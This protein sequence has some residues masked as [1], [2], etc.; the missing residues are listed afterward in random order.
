[1]AHPE[2]TS[3]PSEQNIS[4]S[5]RRSVLTELIPLAVI[6]AFV[7]I[8]MWPF[9]F[10]GM[11]LMPDSWKSIHPWA[12]GVDIYQDETSIYDTVLEYGPWYEY[13]QQCLMDGRVPHWNQMQFC[14][15]PLY[16]N[17][18][19]PFFYPPFIVAELIGGPHTIIGWFQ[20]FNLVLSGWGMFFLLR[21]W[22]LS[23]AVSTCGSLLWL[24]CGVHILPFPLWTLGATGF[25]WLLWALEGFLEKPGVRHV[26]IA[27][28]IM[29]LILLAGY[30]ILIVQLSYFSVIYFIARWWVTRRVGPNRIHWIIPLGALIAV[31]LL[32]FGISAIANVPAWNYSR[33]TVRHV[34]GF[35]DRAF[36]REKRMLL[37][38]EEEAGMDPKLAYFGE[39]MDTILP[40]NGRGTYRAWMFGGVLLYLLALL[41]ILTGRMRAF[42][43]GIIGFIFSILV[44]IPEGYIALLG[45]LPGWRLTIL[46]PIAVVNLAACMLAPLGLEALLDKNYRPDLYGKIL[47]AFLATASIIMTALVL[48]NAP[49]I[50]LPLMKLVQNPNLLGYSTFHRYW[51]ISGSI[52]AIAVALL[53]F[54]INVRLSWLR[55]TVIVA[56]IGFS[57]AT[58]NYLQPFYS[59]HDYMP[60]TPF[61]DE[62]TELT[63]DID[64]SEGNRMARW[65]VL[66]L[67]FNPHKRTKSPF[68]P[69]VHMLYGIYDVGGYDSLVPRRFI[70]Y[71]TV[72]EDAF[73]DYRALIAFRNPDSINH[74]R[75]LDLGVRWVVTLGELPEKNR[76]GYTLVW[77][78]RYDGNR[79]GTDDSDDF[80]QMWEVNNPRPRAFLT[81][82]IAWLSDPAD[83]PL[84]QLT[85]W[86]VR[87]ID[88]VVVENPERENRTFAFPDDMENGDGLVLDGSTVDIT[89]DD[90]EWIEMDVNSREESWLVLRDGWNP[91]WKAYV[92]G[93]E[94]PIYPADAAF[95]AVHVPAG[96]HTIEFRYI[97]RAF[98]IGMW[99]TIGTLLLMILLYIVSGGRTRY[100]SPTASNR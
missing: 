18:I 88:A 71:C 68:T 97:P 19:I 5:P 87:G 70:D 94:T 21:R 44:W 49:V 80:I 65:A 92:D 32:G 81:R 77:D 36:E 14:G 51:F 90:P 27:A 72:F 67:P 3:S 9:T 75:F 25:P 8:Q 48:R 43:I 26:M 31:Y 35:V 37:T 99:I 30:P 62:L 4:A 11:A 54:F 34:E 100:I 41:G 22:R 42:Q 74:P 95:R 6:T 57:L 61:T 50:N 63:A 10:G 73:I 2:I 76:Q 40:I 69:N 56:A 83:N 24:T 46:Q 23:R 16:A 29:G 45:V 96:N 53:V 59:R 15:A 38:P 52:I 55:W 39:R 58:F 13:S 20:L 91:Q 85:N 78:D 7:V 86:S 93:V 82:K 64:P 66:P 84:V 1:V 98:Q 12:R 79:D 47:F 89:R 17:R 28:F 60:P 33:Q